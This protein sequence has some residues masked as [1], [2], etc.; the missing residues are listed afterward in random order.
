MSNRNRY[1]AIAGFLTLITFLIIMITGMIQS[2]IVGNGFLFIPSFTA[3]A[4]ASFTHTVTPTTTASI[5]HTI[6]PTTTLT[7]VDTIDLLRLHTSIART[8]DSNKVKTEA[9]RTKTFTPTLTLT[10]ANTV[11]MRLIETQ[12][13]FTYLS[14]LTETADAIVNTATPSMV[15]NEK[16]YLEKKIG[17]DQ[18]TMILI[19]DSDNNFWIDK[20]EV[21]CQQYSLCVHNG[22]CDRVTQVSA[23]DDPNLPIVNVNW[24]QASAYCEWAGKHLATDYEWILAAGIDFNIQYPWG[25]ELPD[26]KRANTN[27]FFERRMEPGM[28]PPGMSPYGLMDMMGN[29]WEWTE[30]KESNDSGPEQKIRGGSWRTSNNLIGLDLSGK[31]QK[32]ESSMDVGFRCAS[33][34]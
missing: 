8:I 12:V 27:L 31:M 13:I 20:Y 28:Y 22:K 3:T 19:Q 2:I 5:T 16:G 21:T 15:L 4:T 9:A 23:D 26:E 33:S 30:S 32:T 18:S 24:N 1:L 6:T 34:Q 7:P 25:N 14:D 29:V 10:P 17:N 11:D